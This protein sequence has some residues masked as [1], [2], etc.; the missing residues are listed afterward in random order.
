MIWKGGETCPF[1]PTWAPAPPSVRDME[2]GQGAK[3]STFCLATM[4][5]VPDLTLVPA[6]SLSWRS[7]LSQWHLRF[8]KNPVPPRQGPLNF[9]SAPPVIHIP[10]PFLWLGLGATWTDQ[11]LSPFSWSV[12]LLFGAALNSLQGPWTTALGGLTLP[13]PQT[14]QTRE[15]CWHRGFQLIPSAI[16]RPVPV[17]CISTPRS[18]T[19]ELPSLLCFERAS[20]SLQLPPLGI[21]WKSSSCRQP[22]SVWVILMGSLP[23]DLGEWKLPHGEG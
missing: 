13:T 21:S 14:H 10:S 3:L 22:S 4:D 11:W 20:G 15:P 9:P 8:I 6:W 23:L 7:L 1:T 17:F 5:R 2:E 12:V 18:H 19:Q 16:C